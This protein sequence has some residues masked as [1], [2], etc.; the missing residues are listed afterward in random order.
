MSL[1]IFKEVL[2]PSYGRIR[3]T[4]DMIPRKYGFE[5]VP[6]R[7]RVAFFRGGPCQYHGAWCNHARAHQLCGTCS[8]W[9]DK[10]YSLLPKKALKHITGYCTCYAVHGR[11]DDH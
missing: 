1:K 3:P 9:L 5:E 6:H 8:G 10:P 11:K 7:V 2:K 4:Y